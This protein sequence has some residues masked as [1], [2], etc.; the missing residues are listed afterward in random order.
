[1]NPRDGGAWWAAVY[2]V[3]QSRTWLKWLSSSKND[4]N[5]EF[6]HLIIGKLH[7]HLQWH[8]SFNSVWRREEKGTTEDEMVGWHHWLN[9][10]KFEQPLGVGDGQGSLACCTPWGCKKSDT[11][12]R[13]NWAEGKWSKF[14]RKTIF[15]TGT[16]EFV[17]KKASSW[18]VQN[19]GCRDSLRGL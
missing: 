18:V 9:G 10:H 11:T 3:T 4:D 16:N 17:R 8:D 1:M 14:R 19:P 5:L 13:L 12:E 6:N 2:G 15:R 7:A